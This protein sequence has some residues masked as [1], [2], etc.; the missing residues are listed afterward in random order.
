MPTDEQT[1]LRRLAQAKHR[2]AKATGQLLS[3][4]LIGWTF[5]A[6]QESVAAGLW[7]C[8]VTGLAVQVWGG[9]EDDHDG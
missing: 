7:M 2:F 5:G 4:I 9:D 1:L 6:W 8:F 3:I